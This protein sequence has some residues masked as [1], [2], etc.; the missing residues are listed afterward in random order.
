MRAVTKLSEHNR[1]WGEPPWQIAFDPQARVLPEKVD[2]AIV[3]G[4]FTG[5]AAAA[6][7]AHLAPEKTVAVLEA[8]RIGAGASGRTGGVA[9]AGTAV[10]DLPGLGDVLQGFRALLEERHIEC[11][12]VLSGSWEIGRHFARKDSPIRWRDSGRLHVV[13]EVPGG[14]VDPGKML[15]GLAMAAERRGVVLCQRAPVRD[16]AFESPL[17]LHL[18]TC[19]LRADQVLFATNAQALELSGLAGHATPEFTLALATAPL[20]EDQL[21]ALGVSERKPFYTVDL[22][23][24]WGRVLANNGIVFGGGLVHAD[25]WRELDGIDVERG[26][27]A[28][29]LARLEQRVRGLHPALRDVEITNRWGGPI[30]FAKGWQPVFSLHPRT[31]HAVVLGAYAGH[32]VALSVFLGCWAAEV[33]LGRRELPAWGKLAD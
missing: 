24:L 14:T 12:L 4:G 21:E 11:E 2:I 1:R 22:P 15:C 8:D 5:L 30:L 19:E 26:Q 10:G 3:G 16:V 9:L 28:E 7:L 18:P 31:P 29:L 25:D 17:R 6:R 27:A 32:G 20:E 13:A 23:Y 33:L